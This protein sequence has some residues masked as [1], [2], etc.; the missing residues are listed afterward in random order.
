MN[1][2]LMRLYAKRQLT[3]YEMGLIDYYPMN[4]G[5]GNY[6]YDKAQGAHAEL[7]GA[8]WALPRGMSLHLDWNEEKPVKGI[9]LLKDRMIRSAEDDYTLMFWFKTNDNG[10]GALV[11]NGSGR[12]TDDN[13]APTASTLVLRAINSSI[14]QTA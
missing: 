2:T 14:A 4:E 8:A 13:A 6:A 5:E 9:K 1:T 10:K 7:N 12:A 3:G 11:S